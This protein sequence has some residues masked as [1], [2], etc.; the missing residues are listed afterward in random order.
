MNKQLF[1]FIVPILLF[2]AMLTSCS[3][4]DDYKGASSTVKGTISS[5]HADWAEVG[6]SFD[7]G[8]TWAVTTPISN[9]KFT[10][11]LPTPDAKYL[12]PIMEDDDMPAAI[13]VSDKNAIGCGAVFCVRK[14]SQIEE[15]VLIDIKI[16]QTVSISAV[17]YMYVDRKVNITGSYDDEDGKTTLD[18]KLKPGWNTVVATLKASKSG[19]ITMTVKTGNPPSGAVWVAGDDEMGW[20]GISEISGMSGKSMIEKFRGIILK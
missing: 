20:F 17:S 3:K 10:L 1:S 4:D 6:V 16:A 11:E 5:E 12:E 2:T 8:D 15:M 9:G 13:K 18:M 19:K 14:G 7:Y